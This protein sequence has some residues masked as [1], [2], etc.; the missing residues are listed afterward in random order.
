[1]KRELILQGMGWGHM[2][3]FL[4]EEDLAAGRLVTLSGPG[5]TG[6][7]AELV[8]ARRRDVPHGPVAE[9]LW[10]QIADQAPALKHPGAGPTAGSLSRPRR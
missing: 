9:R 4:V 2:P 3:R 6:G 1:M 8:A 7:V 10:R 5:L